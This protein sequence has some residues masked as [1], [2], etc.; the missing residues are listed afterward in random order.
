M[1]YS[2]GLE[3]F[4]GARELAQPAFPSEEAYQ[5]FREDFSAVMVPFLRENARKH[6]RS[7]YELF[8]Q[9]LVE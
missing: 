7:Y 6:A 4:P 8:E 9:G 1:D 3:L 5:R 2:P